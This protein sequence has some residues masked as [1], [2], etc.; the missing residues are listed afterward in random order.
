MGFAELAAEIGADLDAA[1][2]AV[3]QHVHR[4]GLGGDPLGGGL[5]IGHRPHVEGRGQG[6]AARCADFAGD[7]LGP[8]G[9][10]VVDGDGQARGPQL[11]GDA[12]A[13]ALAGSSHQRDAACRTVRHASSP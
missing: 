12:A 6:L 5:H 4:A 13:H 2:G 10:P 8:L 1:A 3:D 11:Q 9:A 7:H